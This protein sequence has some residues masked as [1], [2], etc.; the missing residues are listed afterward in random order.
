MITSSVTPIPAE[1]IK[2]GMSTPWWTALADAE[3]KGAEVHIRI[4]SIPDGG[5]ET[6]VW[7]LGTEIPSVTTS[8]D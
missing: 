6:R 5:R 4:E 8:K 2:S 7:D 3:V 1:Q